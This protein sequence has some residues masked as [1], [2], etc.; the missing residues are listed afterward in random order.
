MDPIADAFFSNYKFFEFNNDVAQGF[1]L[2]VELVAGGVNATSLY[3]PVYEKIKGNDPS[4][5]RWPAEL[6][7]TR[8]M[9]RQYAMV[10]P[11]RNR[12]QAGRMQ[13]TSDV[14]ILGIWHCSS[15]TSLCG[16]WAM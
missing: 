13:V 5:R 3:L 4:D 16:S 10:L 8:L 7:E 14:D 12:N 6:F 9:I 15:T 1:S 2:S 11:T